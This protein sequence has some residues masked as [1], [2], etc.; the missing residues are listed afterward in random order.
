MENKIMA[1][2]SQ[3]KANFIPAVRGRDT[4]SFKNWNQQ[5]EQKSAPE[6]AEVK[7]TQILPVTI[8]TR[9]ATELLNANLP[10]A[11]KI[12][13]AAEK[14]IKTFLRLTLVVTSTA[15]VLAAPTTLVEK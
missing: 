10:R 6:E 3:E 4:S 13:K 11:K 15:T 12:I 8:A 14:E 2:K 5:R 7:L 1:P 9:K